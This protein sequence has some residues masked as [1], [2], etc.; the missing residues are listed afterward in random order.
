MN[1]LS[2]IAAIG[3]NNELGKDNKLI[4]FLK[5]DLSFFRK[6][7]INKTIIMG[8]N[9]YLS[10]PKVLDNRKH[11]V[12]TKQHLNVPENVYVYND[13]TSLKRY[14]NNTNE[15]MIV[16]GG[17]KIYS[18]FIDDVDTMLLTEIDDTCDMADTYFPFFDKKE[19][20][21]EIISSHE[22]NGIKYNHVKYL[23]RSNYGK[24]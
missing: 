17:S 24:G 1:N 5:E 19:W 10:L 4:W 20:K 14:I 18:L 23:R 2:L 21:Q 13:Y 9:T 16:I 15:E 3:K 12:L 7:T 22:D 8:R 11:I 6:Y